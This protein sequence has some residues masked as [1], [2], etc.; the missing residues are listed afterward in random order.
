MDS[1]DY[2]RYDSLDYSTGLER[3]TDVDTIDR[4]G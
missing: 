2:T 1:H 3:C 4:G